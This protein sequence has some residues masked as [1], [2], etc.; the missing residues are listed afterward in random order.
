MNTS[1][2]PFTVIHRMGFS[3][4]MFAAG[5][6]SIVAFR[7]LLFA[8]HDFV[9]QIAVSTPSVLVACILNLIVGSI[10][11]LVRR[12]RSEASM[13]PRLF[14]YSFTAP[15]IMTAL[16]FAGAHLADLAR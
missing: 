2:Q 6:F 9:P 16:L 5:V 1:A 3:I 8:L 12:R 14:F 10:A 13:P 4:G 7:I 11:V 15:A